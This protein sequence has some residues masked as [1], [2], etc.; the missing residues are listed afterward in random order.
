MSIENLFQ[1]TIG[2]EIYKK[3]TK[4]ISDFS[5]EDM[6]KSG[7]LVGFSGGADS[8][9]LLLFLLEYRKHVNFEITAVHVNHG[10]RGDEASRD[11]SF[12][13]SFVEG[14]G[15]EF[16]SIS[17][18]VPNA[19]IEMG[20]GIEEV[21]RSLRYSCF[22]DIIFGRNDISTVAVAHNASDNLETVIMN[23]MRGSGI[24]GMSGIQPVRDNIIRPLIY[25]SKDDIRKALED[26][27]IPFVIDSTN[28]SSDYRRNYIRNEIFPLFFK[29]ASSPEDVVTRLCESL[30]CDLDY[31]ERASSDFYS[32]NL[33]LGKVITDSL[34][35]LHP[36]IRSR[37]IMRMALD[38]EGASCEKVHVDKI[39]SLLGKDF[40]YDLP[41]GITFVSNKDFSY[42]TKTEGVTSSFEYDVKLSMGENSL[43]NLDAVVILSSTPLDA[44]ARE[45]DTENTS[46][47][48]F[49]NVYKK[50]IQQCIDFDII[51]GDLRVRSRR[52][53]DSYRYGNITHKVKKIFNDKKIPVEIRNKIPVFYDEDGIVWIPGFSAR[54]GVR[55]RQDTENKLYITVLYDR[56]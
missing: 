6:I 50:S 54:D 13:K 19:A 31:I 27:E 4:A 48:T 37:V 24:R 10:I 29:L 30:R 41:G 56:D 38:F 2:K 43:N 21:A 9:M 18:D 1:T 32:T 22:S 16:L 7:V 23:M 34:I 5:M 44:A 53:G 3:A 25:V 51:K 26:S 42:V 15:V 8:V 11:E 35:S 17:V 12:S 28:L 49:S 52:D 55:N 20:K 40:S 39:S 45:F 46:I 36:A 14:L 47:K 33:N